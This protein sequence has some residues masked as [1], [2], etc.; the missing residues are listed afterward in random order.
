MLMQEYFFV[1]LFFLNHCHT[2]N[3]NC[4]LPC[5][6]YCLNY[7]KKHPYERIWMLLPYQYYISLLFYI[8]IRMLLLHELCLYNFYLKDTDYRSG[9]AVTKHFRYSWN[10][11]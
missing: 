2:L 9:T 5:L 4:K 1:N 6:Q 8:Q 3:F 11:R 7:K 10:F